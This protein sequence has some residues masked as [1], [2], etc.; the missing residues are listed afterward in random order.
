MRQSARKQLL[1]FVAGLNTESSP[2]SFPENT[3][4]ALDNVDLLRDA[5]IRRRRGFDF[6]EGGVYSPDTWTEEVLSRY[7]VNSAKWTSVGGDD[8]LNFFVI[9]IGGRLFFHDAGSDVTSASLIGSISMEPIRTDELY[10]TE[11]MEFDSA[12]GR[13]FVVNKYMSPSYIEYDRDSN[14][15]RG[16]KLT[17]KIRDVE[18]IDDTR[19]SPDVFGDAITPP[20]D[21]NPSID[22]LD[23]LDLLDSL[24]FSTWFSGGIGRPY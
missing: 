11:P 4:K 12:K 9:Q 7:S 3:A 21:F 18:G 10:D 1:T 6:E 19:S 14:T 23:L 17:L 16:I 15:F 13:L 2:L 5:S 22:F 8:N 20:S 24:D